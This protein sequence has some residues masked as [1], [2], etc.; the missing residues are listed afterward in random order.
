MGLVK[1]GY[2]V[3]RITSDH[4]NAIAGLVENTLDG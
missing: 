2:E 4:G 3:F 1:C